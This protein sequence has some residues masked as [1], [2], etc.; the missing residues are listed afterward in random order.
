M[1]DTQ[2]I[3]ERAYFLWLRAGQPQ[4]LADEFWHAASSAEKMLK[5][6]PGVWPEIDEKIVKDENAKLLLERA[7]AMMKAQD[8]GMRAMESR[9]STLLGISVTLGTAAVAA[10]ITALGTTAS[11]LPWIQPWT[12]PT[13]SIMVAFW[14]GAILVAAVTM[15]GSKW[16][17]AGVSPVNLYRATFLSQ[18]T[19]RLRMNLAHTLQ[20]GISDN[21]KTV[22]K[23]ALRLKIVV[24]LLA[25]A[26]VAAALAIIWSTRAD[27][28]RYL[29]LIWR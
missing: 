2:R 28:L 29:P 13:L 9:M 25:G 11:P 20:D 17:V 27:L 16:A 12:I 15:M 5:A 1:S 21:R 23:Y 22:N 26:P 18:N 24:V 3:S 8:D 14:I 6:P 7:D 10:E 4:G 19:N